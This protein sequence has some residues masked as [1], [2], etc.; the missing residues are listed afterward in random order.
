MWSLKIPS[1]SSG[2][3]YTVTGYDDGRTTCTC[4]SGEKRG[5]RPAG[6]PSCKHMRSA[7][8]Q[9][10]LGYPEDV[11]L[12][13][14]YTDRDIRFD[15]PGWV[16]HFCYVFSPVDYVREIVEAIMRVDNEHI[17]RAKARDEGGGNFRPSP[18]PEQERAVMEVLLDALSDFD[19]DSNSPSSEMARLFL[20]KALVI[21]QV[22]D[23]T[24]QQRAAAIR[25]SL[26]GNDSQWNRLVGEEGRGES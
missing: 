4:P 22:P 12:P 19:Q 6:R 1:L 11:V 5:P 20:E 23:T 16:R 21:R 10:E 2:E 7:I 17:S 24:N 15:G 8:R 14:A 18:L 3:I 26:C 25:N 9:H 13:P